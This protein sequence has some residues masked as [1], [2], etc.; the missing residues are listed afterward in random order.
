MNEPD[1][2]TWMLVGKHVRKKD[3]SRFKGYVQAMFLTRA[4]RVRVVVEADSPD[5]L[6]M[7]HIYRPDQLEEVK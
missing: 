7:L 2:P 3:G 5:Y 6:G 1:V 4:Q